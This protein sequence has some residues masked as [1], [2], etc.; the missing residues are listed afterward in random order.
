MK[1]TILIVALIIISYI[2]VGNIFSEKIIIPNE[3]IRIRVIANSNSDYDQMIK[4]KINQSL[5]KQDKPKLK[6][7]KKNTKK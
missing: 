4:N 7:K 5:Q 1:K 6:S 3:A 2:I